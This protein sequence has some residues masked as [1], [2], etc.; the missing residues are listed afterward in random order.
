MN[1]PVAALEGRNLVKTYPSGEGRITVL[2]DCDVK[3]AA[4]EMLAVVGPSGVGKSTLLHLLGGLDRPDSGQV[5][6]GGQDLASLSRDGRA[7]QRNRSIGFV[8]QFH[9]LLPD[10]TAEENVMMPLQVGRMP[11]SQAKQRARQVLEE[12]GLGARGHHTPPELSGG[13]RQRVAI[14]RAL[15]QQPQVLLADEP[16][17]NLDPH[18][19]GSVFSALLDLQKTRKL[20]VILVTHA[21][22]LANR[23]DRIATLVEGGRFARTP[24]G[25]DDFHSDSA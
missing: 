11:T 3:V 13:E 25:Q 20:A 17:G 22:E 6:V 24:S 7:A 4:G 5:L 23:C 16:T 2:E 18:T 14:G 21:Q 19:A 10:F 9:H 8:F 15:V 12:L 1:S